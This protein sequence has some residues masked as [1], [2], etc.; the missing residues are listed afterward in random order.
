M[1]LSTIGYGGKNPNDFFK[2]L[3]ELKPD[4][5]IDVRANPCHA[6]LPCY[7]KPLLEKIIAYY[8]IKYMWLPQ[9]G[10][11]S[12]TLPPKLQDESHCIKRI[13]YL[14]T[15]CEHIVLLCAEKDEKRCHRLFI[16]EKVEE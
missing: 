8:G 9:C 15:Q 5:V 12:R 14:L 2:E 11:A 4:L 13:K 7:T 1:T 3:E 6:F 10:N 16:K